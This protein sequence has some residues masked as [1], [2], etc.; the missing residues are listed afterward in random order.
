VWS[1][2]WFPGAAVM[3]TAVEAVRGGGVLVRMMEE[4]HGPD[5]S[6]HALR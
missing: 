4:E 1:Q 5:G 6:S 3:A 2:R